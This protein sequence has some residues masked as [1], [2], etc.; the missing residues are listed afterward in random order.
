M[1][2][3][4]GIGNP[5]QWGLAVKVLTAIG[6]LYQPEACRIGCRV[7]VLDTVEVALDPGKVPGDRVGDGQWQTIESG[8][9]PA[10]DRTCGIAFGQPYLRVGAQQ[11]VVLR[12]GRHA[13][14]G[15]PADGRQGHRPAQAEGAVTGAVVVVQR[16]G[17]RIA[18]CGR[19][20]QGNFKAGHPAGAD[21]APAF[22]GAFGQGRGIDL[23]VERIV[24]HALPPLAAGTLAV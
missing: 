17:W 9:G 7:P 10:D 21:I 13:M 1:V 12:V 18:A 6:T 2:R 3:V 4:V 11:Y 19:N 22:A 14:G 23:Q 16:H 8:R 24:V 20:R 5:G 15:T